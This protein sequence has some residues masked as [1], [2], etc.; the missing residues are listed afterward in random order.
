MAKDIDG[1][2]IE[3]GK[4]MMA[5]AKKLINE[6]TDSDAMKPMHNEGATTAASPEMAYTHKLAH[7]RWRISTCLVRCR[8]LRDPCLW[9]CA[10]HGLCWPFSAF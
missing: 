9:T 8:A 2:S 4:E 7:A 3:H 6:V 5:H 1:L 10:S